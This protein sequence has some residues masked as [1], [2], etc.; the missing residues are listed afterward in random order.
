MKL[1]TD[2]GMTFSFSNEISYLEYVFVEGVSEGLGLG[3]G[4]Q[5]TDGVVSLLGQTQRLLWYY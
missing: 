5:R 4:Q 2:Y 3:S 1:C